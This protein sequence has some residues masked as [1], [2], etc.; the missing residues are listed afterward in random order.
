MSF[1]VICVT[2]KKTG[3]NGHDAPQLEIGST[4]T[5]VKSAPYTNGVAYKLAE[6]DPTPP[7]KY[8]CGK[9]FAPISGISDEEIEEE[10]QEQEAADL[11]RQFAKI[12]HEHENA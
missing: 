5:V 3:P 1:K 10:Y 12:V 4:Y 11:D 8:F 7:F 9:Y 2:N 6:V